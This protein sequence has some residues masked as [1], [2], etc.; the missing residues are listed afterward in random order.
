MFSQVSAKF[1]ARGLH[2]PISVICAVVGLLQELVHPGNS[3]VSHSSGSALPVV[4]RAILIRPALL[5]I[6]KMHRNATN[7][8]ERCDVHSVFSCIL[9]IKSLRFSEKNYPRDSF[10]SN[11]R[12]YGR[13]GSAKLF[14]GFLLWVR[15]VPQIRAFLHWQL[16][17]EFVVVSCFGYVRYRRFGHFFSGNG[18]GNL[19][20][21]LAL[22]EYG[23]A[24]SGIFFSGN[25][26]GN[27][28]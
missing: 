22:G 17:W 25:G 4:F 23:S 26:F 1:G 13:S 18:F 15:T 27:L 8:R 7:R 19:S 14:H 10:H 16:L 11:V 2:P 28:S 9:P 21:F 5:S 20:M 12:A 6:H 3:S 24:D